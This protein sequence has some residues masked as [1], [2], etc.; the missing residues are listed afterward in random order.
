MKKKPLTAMQVISKQIIEKKAIIRN[1]QG[2]KIKYQINRRLSQLNKLSR[3]GK[4]AAKKREHQ[5][6]SVRAKADHVFAFVKR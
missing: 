6:S 5:K 3:S 2:K 1:K 4:Y